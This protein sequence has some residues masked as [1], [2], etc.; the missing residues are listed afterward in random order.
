MK[1]DSNTPSWDDIAEFDAPITNEQKVPSWDDIAQMDGEEQVPSIQEDKYGLLDTIIRKGLQGASFGLS[2]EAVGGLSAV[3]AKLTGED[4]SFGD[5]YRKYRDEERQTL[6]EMGE[7]SPVLSAVADIG[8]S[9]AP[10]LATGGMGLVPKLLGKGAQTAAASG[11]AAKGGLTAMNTMA[12]LGAA[13]G[14]LHGI[15]RNEADLTDGVSGEEVESLGTDVAMGAGIGAL[16]PYVIGAAGKTARVAGDATKKA[17]KFLG[18]TFKPVSDIGEHLGDLFKLGQKYKDT[19]FK[20]AGANIVNKGSNFGMKITQDAEKLLDEVNGLIKQKKTLSRG[21]LNSASDDLLMKLNELR[22][23]DGKE[24]ELIRKEIFDNY[25]NRYTLD[26]DALT[27][28]FN[29]AKENMPPNVKNKIKELANILEKDNFSL[30]SALKAENEL[31]TLLKSD[32]SKKFNIRQDEALSK[33][34]DFLNKANKKVVEDFQLT[35]EGQDLSKQLIKKN[36]IFHDIRTTMDELFGGIPSKK[37]SANIT[38]GTKEG[39]EVFGFTEINPD[40]TPAAGAPKQTSRPAE[41]LELSGRTEARPEALKTAEAIG[42]FRKY[43]VENPEIGKLGLGQKEDAANLFGKT[44]GKPNEVINSKSLDTTIG[45]LKVQPTTF[46]DKTRLKNLLE[47]IDMS[48]PPDVATSLKKEAEDISH[49]YFRFTDAYETT[50]SAGQDISGLIR[51]VKKM[52]DPFVYKMGQLSKTSGVQA[53]L[54]ALTPTAQKTRGVLSTLPTFQ[55]PTTVEEKLTMPQS[56]ESIKQ[57]YRDSQR[58][59]DVSTDE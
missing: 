44:F 15:G 58:G 46:M 26:R 33:I 35:G 5:L 8:G 43:D 3:G 37:T 38:T 42:E 25:S 57:G 9:I 51:F 18:E 55:K 19:S 39:T 36:A 20:Q 29:E 4:G 31:D 17:G 47:Y 32:S 27:K 30:K 24:I 59:A 22:K 2:D 28:V 41:F 12:K 6:K 45:N 1:K 56:F 13:E 53:P 50:T 21:E 40:L 14:A 34:K 23:R 10:V 54:K 16:A 49:E 52:S 11:L 48:Y 7:E